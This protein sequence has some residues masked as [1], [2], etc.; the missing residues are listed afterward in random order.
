MERA[1]AS[2]AFQRKLYFLMGGASTVKSDVFAYE[3]EQM[4]TGYSDLSIQ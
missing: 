4:F 2:S 1:S 3:R